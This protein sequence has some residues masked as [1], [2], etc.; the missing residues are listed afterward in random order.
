M[1]NLSIRLSVYP[2]LF[3]SDGGPR[4]FLRLSAR[5]SRPRLPSSSLSSALR[6]EVR[7]PLPAWLGISDSASPSQ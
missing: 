4:F 2:R 3:L 6:Q 7:F 5:P 1:S